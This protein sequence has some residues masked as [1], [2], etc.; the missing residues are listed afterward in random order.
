[1]AEGDPHP[2][3]RRRGPHAAVPGEAAA[4]RGAARPA[5]APDPEERARHPQ[6]APRRHLP[7][8]SRVPRPHAGARPRGRGA[9]SS[10]SRRCSSTSSRRWS[11]RAAAAGAPEEDPR[12]ELV[13]RLLEY[14]KYKGVAET[15][16][17][18]EAVRLGLW[19]RAPAKLETPEGGG[20]GD[21]PLGSLAL[22]PADV[23][24]G[25]ARPLPR[26]AP[27]RRWRSNTRSSPSRRR[28]SRCS[29]A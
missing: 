6:P 25:C 18:M 8:V 27:A 21:G 11:C 28:W 22:R 9:S 5:A 20:R 12:D 26:A 7:A 13:R 23:L 29:R 15:L 1:M 14:R 17:E 10:T 16:H 2:R 4:V 3:P 19:S 24:Q